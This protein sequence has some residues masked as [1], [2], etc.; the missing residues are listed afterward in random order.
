MI[1]IDKTTDSI[2]SETVKLSPSD[3]IKC[4]DNIHHNTN[5][6]NN[7]KVNRA[8][9]NDEKDKSDNNIIKNTSSDIWCPYCGIQ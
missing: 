8:V 9:N 6:S 2:L 5:T 7:E 3:P 4:Q 1:D